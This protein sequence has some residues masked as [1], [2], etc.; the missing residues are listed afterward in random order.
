ML[1]IH[2]L[3]RLEVTYARID[4]AERTERKRICAKIVKKS[5]FPHSVPVMLPSDKIRQL[6]L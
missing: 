6:A 2:G 1:K 3:L 5:S 4:Y